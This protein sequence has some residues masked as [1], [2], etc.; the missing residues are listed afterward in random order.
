M[1]RDVEELASLLSRFHVVL[2]Y[3][4]DGAAL[5]FQGETPA[6][7]RR[8]IRAH[9]RGLALLMLQGDIRLCPCPE[10]HRREWYYVGSGR[11][12]C[13]LCQKLDKAQLGL[14]KVG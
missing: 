9:R 5:A 4:K 3:S 6:E 1:R 10:R 13:L 11:Y 14:W 12:A 2:S 8:Q 7:L